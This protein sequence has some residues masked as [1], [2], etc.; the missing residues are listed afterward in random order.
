VAFIW[1]IYFSA[2]DGLL[3]SHMS[4]TANVWYFSAVL[5]GKLVAR[6]LPFTE[7]T[8]V[9]H[10]LPCGTFQ[11]QEE[12]LMKL[13]CTMML[14][15]NPVMV[16]KFYWNRFLALTAR[17]LLALP[18][19]TTRV[20]QIRACT[21]S[22]S[23][24]R[25]RSISCSCSAESWYADLVHSCYTRALAMLKTLVTES[26]LAFWLPR[27]H[28]P[29]LYLPTYCPLNFEW[30]LWI[31]FETYCCKCL[32]DFHPPR[33]KYIGFLGAW[34]LAMELVVLP[35]YHQ[36]TTGCGAGYGGREKNH[37]RSRF[38]P[39]SIGH[40][41]WCNCL[42]DVMLVPSA[43]FPQRLWPWLA[44]SA[45]RSLVQRRVTHQLK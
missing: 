39:A 18:Q 42:Y 1:N 17:K 14:A 29:F 37:C 2:Y 38:L 44:F 24:M 10:V 4:V 15:R 3:S 25:I 8:L 26:W 28:L 36:R 20:L 23:S 6:F 45:P 30:Y 35:N 33:W 13:F 9:V 5:P 19:T 22:W 31:D 43:H 16:S 32:I 21:W 41:F 7:E 12:Q 34:R 27:L 11:Q 40:R